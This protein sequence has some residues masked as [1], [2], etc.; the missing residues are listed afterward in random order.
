[1]SV[2]LFIRT[3][4]ADAGWLELCFKSIQKYVS[5]YN[6]IHIAVPA[7]DYPRLPDVGSS[8][9]HLVHDNC[10]G[11]L[12]QQVTKLYADEYCNAD[13]ICHVDSDCIFNVPLNV[14]DLIV[15]GKPVYL[16]EDGVE[17]PWPPI[18]RKALGWDTK[19]DYMRRHPFVFPRPLYS[20]FRAW[21]K[22]KHEMELKDYI[23][24]QPRHEFSEFNT[25]GAWCDRY[26]HDQFE[27]KHPSEFPTYLLQF[28][29]YGGVEK[30]RQEIEKILAS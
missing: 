15:D 5:G 2:D 23:G 20:E 10:T 6:K 9:V 22:R 3:Y 28:W 13:F 21:M 29:S 27:W 17:S 24:S 16:V 18:M 26:R 11:Y 1:V 30:H 19:T 7:N 12:A 8:E 4:A 25:F 14:E